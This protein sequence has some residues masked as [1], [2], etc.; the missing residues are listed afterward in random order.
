MTAACLHWFSSRQSPA[1]LARTGS[2]G[3]S[4]RSSHFRFCKEAQ[5]RAGCK[6]IAVL[7]LFKRSKAE[8][9][10]CL[11]FTW[12]KQ[13]QKM[14]RDVFN[15]LR[16]FSLSCGAEPAEF[17]KGQSAGWMLYQRNQLEQDHKTLGCI[18]KLY[19]TAQQTVL[20]WAVQSWLAGW[21]SGCSEG[22]G[23]ADW[24]GGQNPRAAVAADFY[25]NPASP[26]ASNCRSLTKTQTRTTQRKLVSTFIEEPQWEVH[27]DSLHLTSGTNPWLTTG[28][29]WRK[30][31]LLLCLGERQWDR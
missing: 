7:E 18:P 24:P 17:W 10:N 2:R 9:K 23:A 25:S 1:T 3:L 16:G 20:P 26:D 8:A 14:S 31:L 5:Q 28:L 11:V 12:M 6:S 22:P 30:I 19:I 21:P 29:R 15:R 13:V 4:F 27:R